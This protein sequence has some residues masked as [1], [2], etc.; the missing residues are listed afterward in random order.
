MFFQF[1]KKPFLVKAVAIFLILQV[2][3]LMVPLFIP[4]AHAL[5]W[6]D[7]TDSNDPKEVKRRPDHFLLFDWMGNAEKDLKK[8]EYRDKDNRDKGPGVNS[9]SKAMVVIASGLVG[10]GL[11][12]V[13]ANYATT[14]GGDLNSNLFLGGALGLCAGVAVGALIIPADY[15]KNPRAQIDFMKDRQ[16]W[17]QDPVRLQIAQAFQPSQV[18]FQVKF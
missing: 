15:E 9:G 2:S 14:D 11:G 3:G 1:I 13:V 4:K 5:Y 6:E 16:A 10:L 12:L 7:E 8:A 18:S 17:M